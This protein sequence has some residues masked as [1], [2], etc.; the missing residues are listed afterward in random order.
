MKPIRWRLAAISFK[1]WIAFM[2]W[3]LFCILAF[4]PRALDA[5]P[6]SIAFGAVASLVLFYVVAW[7]F[8]AAVDVIRELGALLT[9]QFHG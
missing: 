5:T 1:V 7:L 4:G 2:A 9:K 8:G 3:A 6:E